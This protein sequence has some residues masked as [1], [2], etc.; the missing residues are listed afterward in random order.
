MIAGNLSKKKR[1]FGYVRVS[2]AEQAEHKTSLRQQ[3]VDLKSYCDKQGIE[4]VEIFVEP[5][6]SGSDWRRPEFNRMMLLAT[7]D[8]HPVDFVVAA[9]MARLARDVELIITTQG[10]LRRAGVQCL[11]A[12]QEFEDS[13]FGML[14][15][16]LTGWQD[17]DAIVKASMNTRR[18]LRGTAEE[19]FWSGGTVP[20]GYESRTVEVRGKKEKK[21]LF[22][23]ESEAPIVRKIFDLAER[24]IDG[25][26]M[27]GRAIAEYLNTRGYTRRGKL[28]YNATVAGILSRQHYLG[29]F[30]GNKVNEFGALLPEEEWTWVDCPQIITRE[31]FDRVA[32][33]REQR[34][35]RNT[36]PRVVNGPTLLIGLAECNK[37]GAGMTIRTGKGGRYRYYSCHAK[38]N[39]GASACTCPNVRTETLDELVLDA[40]A[41]RIFSDCKIEPLLQKVLDTSSDAR[42]RKHQEL[43]Q[44]ENRLVE[45]RRRLSNLYDAL[46]AQKA[47]ERDPE[48]A[49]RIKDRRSEIDALNT[50]AKVLRQQLERGPTRITPAAVRRFGQIVREQLLKGDEKVRQNIARTFIN[51]VRVD[52]KVHI[53][54]QTNALAHGAA[55]VARAKGAV[56]SF[57][58]KWCPEEDSNRSQNVAKLRET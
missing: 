53:E 50:T 8:D 32:A 4:L 38:V 51:K 2:T 40:V 48:L 16:L 18:G 9:D 43:Q 14:H 49:L 1:A 55:A 10:Q 52:A 22:I 33:L 24:G 20:L 28:F 6:V 13:H 15:Q 7:G 11:F 46:E 54:G 47:S 34:A 41:E 58:R 36:P 44:C 26:P 25:S 42:Q 29:Q 19:G 39:R 27:G 17:Q 35:P 37:C 5:G 12:Y 31:Q 30:V 56:P 23:S 21:K 3:E 57:D 45:V